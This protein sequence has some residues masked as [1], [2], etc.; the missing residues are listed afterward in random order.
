MTEAEWLACNNPDKMMEHMQSQVSARKRRLFALACCRRIAALLPDEQARAELEAVERNAEE[1]LS[2]Q[3]H[4][5]AWMTL[6]EG[7]RLHVQSRSGNTPWA[8]FAVMSAKVGGWGSA[9]SSAKHAATYGGLSLNE[10]ESQCN[11]L[12]DVV[13]NPFRP[14][15]IED[16]WRTPVVVALANCIYDERSFDRLPK[17]AEALAEAGCTNEDILQH[18]RQAEGHVRGCWVVDLLLAKE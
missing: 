1:G 17:L 8:I 6:A 13:G 5:A 16:S 15:S 18:C 11:L 4:E 7:W 2:K 14:V 12:R 10:T 3:E 9:S